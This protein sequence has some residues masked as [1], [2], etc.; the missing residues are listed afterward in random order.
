LSGL[1]PLDNVIDL[2]AADASPNIFKG[3]EAMMNAAD[4]IIAD[5]TPFR[6][7]GAAAQRLKE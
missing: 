4:A 1:Y 3:N 7:A 2:W 6:G 5:L